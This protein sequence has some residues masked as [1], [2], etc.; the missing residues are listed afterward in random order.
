M[1]RK[2]QCGKRMR[3]APFDPELG[4]GRSGVAVVQTLIAGGTVRGEADDPLGGGRRLVTSART[5][6]VDGNLGANFDTGWNVISVQRLDSGF[7]GLVPA[8]GVPRPRPMS[9]IPGPVRCPTV[10]SLASTP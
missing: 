4:R 6:N 8:P 5:P 9:P 2:G 7:A 1:D 3:V 10:P